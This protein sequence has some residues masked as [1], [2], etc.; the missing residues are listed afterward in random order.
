MVTPVQVSD[1]GKGERILV[2]Q[3]SYLGDVILTTPL[4][5]EIRRCFPEAE[6]DLWECGARQWNCGAVVIP[7]PYPPINHCAAHCFY[8]LPVF[9]AGLDFA[10]ARDGFSI[11]IV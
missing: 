3:T 4:L 6:L 5:A 10:R 9:L 7:W 8:F 11:I 1:G 2:N